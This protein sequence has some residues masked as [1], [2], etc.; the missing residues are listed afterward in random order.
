MHR[1]RVV[2]RVADSSLL[3][4]GSETVPVIR[5]PDRVLVEHVNRVRGP[6]GQ[7]TPRRFDDRNCAFSRRC[8]VQPRSLPS[9]TI[10][11][12]AWDVRH[13]VVEAHHLVVLVARL[14]PLIA[15]QPHGPGYRGVGGRDHASLTGCHVLRRIERERAHGSERT[16]GLP[17]HCAPWPGAA[18]SMIVSPCSRAIGINVVMSAGGRT[19]ELAPQPAIGGDRRPDRLGV[20]TEGH[21]VDVHEHRVAPVSATELAVAAKVNEGRSPVARADTG[22]QHPQ[23][24]C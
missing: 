5:H 9:C 3:Q 19:G 2:H 18:S 24:Q 14:H 7:M 4:R 22:G 21:G 15:Q 23:M 20:D 6:V 13:A 16:H 1:D 17:S 11:I 8:S 12:A 10:P